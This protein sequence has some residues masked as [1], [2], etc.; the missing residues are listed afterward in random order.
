MEAKIVGKEMSQ[1]QRLLQAKKNLAKC[2]SDHHYRAHTFGVIFLSRRL[3][4]SR[5]FKLN[6]TACRRI[7]RAFKSKCFH[8]VTSL[9]QDGSSQYSADLEA[10]LFSP[11]FESQKGEGNNLNQELYPE[12]T[13]RK[14][15]FAETRAM[16]PWCLKMGSTPAAPQSICLWFAWHNN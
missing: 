4:P 11:G 10:S 15:N 12:N 5:I 14:T 3:L 16:L 6:T 13:N 8:P 9:K 7:L 2:F 1:G